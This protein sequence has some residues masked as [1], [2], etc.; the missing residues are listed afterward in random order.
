VKRIVDASPSPAAFDI[1]LYEFS[2]ACLENTMQPRA[3]LEAAEN[4]KKYTNLDCGISLTMPGSWRVMPSPTLAECS[5]AEKSN[6]R[7]FVLIKRE[8]Q[9]SISRRYPEM[10]EDLSRQFLSEKLI[11][12]EAALMGQEILKSETIRIQGHEYESIVKDFP[13]ESASGSSET[14]RVFR[15]VF[16]DDADN[17]SVTCAAPLGLFEEKAAVFRKIVE[18]LESAVENLET[19]SSPAD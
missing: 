19:R 18:G 4:H 1:R 9:T 7:V 5:V 13:G 3:L 11:H 10:S 12:G 15:T 14:T 17:F 2:K 6:Y 8:P 16:W